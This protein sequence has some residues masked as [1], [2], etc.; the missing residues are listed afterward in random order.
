MCHSVRYKAERRKAVAQGF[1]AICS[2]V[3][4]LDFCCKMFVVCVDVLECNRIKVY[5]L[6]LSAL[7][8]PLFWR[9]QG[10]INIHP[11]PFCRHIFCVS[12]SLFLL[13]TVGTEL[14]ISACSLCFTATQCTDNRFGRCLTRDAF[15]KSVIARQHTVKKISADNMARCYELR[16]GVS[17]TVI[18]KQTVALITVTASAF[19]HCLDFCK[20][21]K[22][23]VDCLHEGYLLS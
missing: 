13:C 5:C 1:I 19:N 10:I 7:F 20:L 23:K 18:K 11:R 16:T 14:L 21:L 2:F 9:L 3:R 4:V 12:L 22:G 6:I 17:V 8:K 15:H